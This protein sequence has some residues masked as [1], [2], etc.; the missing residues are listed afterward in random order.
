MWRVISV[1]LLGALA[2]DLLDDEIEVI[3]LEPV[4]ETY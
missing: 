4:A 2:S 1:G 3:S